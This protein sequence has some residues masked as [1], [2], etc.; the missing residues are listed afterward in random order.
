M[1]VLNNLIALKEDTFD[2]LLIESIDQSIAL[3][4]SNPVISSKALA[5]DQ[6][7]QKLL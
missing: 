6:F 2:P 1:Q 5:G 7:D 4:M 3:L